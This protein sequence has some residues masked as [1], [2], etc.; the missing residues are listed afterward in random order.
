MCFNQAVW[1]PD[2]PVLYTVDFLFITFGE[3]IYILY[4]CVMS[5]ETIRKNIY[6]FTQPS[7]LDDAILD[8]KLQGSLCFYCVSMTV[9]LNPLVHQVM[10][11]KYLYF[12]F[13]PTP[14]SVALELHWMVLLFTAHWSA[15]SYSK[16]SIFLDFLSTTTMLA[17]VL[18]TE[19]ICAFFFPFFFLDSIVQSF[20]QAGADVNSKGS[21]ASPLVF[22]TGHGGY[23]NFIRYC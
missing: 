3:W 12:S 1:L 18:L 22:A 16:A 21:V 11:G 8:H 20:W 4:Y 13:S 6:H 19:T 2:R 5:S 15:W 9:N 10:E 14:F 23:T 17:V 7:C